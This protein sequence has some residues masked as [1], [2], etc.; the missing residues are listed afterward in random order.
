MKT[1]TFILLATVLFFVPGLSWTKALGETVARHIRLRR[2]GVRRVLPA[3]TPAPDFDPEALDAYGRGPHRVRDEALHALR[4]EPPRAVVRALHAAGYS[5]HDGW[6]EYVAV[7]PAR[8]MTKGDAWEAALDITEAADLDAR[9]A[10]WTT[11]RPKSGWKRLH[12]K[13]APLGRH[14][15]GATL[16]HGGHWAYVCRHV[17]CKQV[18]WTQEEAALAAQLLGAV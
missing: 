10:E 2:P 5:R 11:E 9:H 4:A 12:D 3:P 7:F 8:T 16:Q 1:A 14:E 17:D 13:G 15:A 6:P 18:A